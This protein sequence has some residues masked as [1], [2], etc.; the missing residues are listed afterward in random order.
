[1]TQRRLLTVVAILLLSFG[2]TP[3]PRVANADESTG[4]PA[5]DKDAADGASDEIKAAN[6]RIA[7]VLRDRCV[8]CHGES[9]E[10]MGDVDLF[11]FVKQLP[12]VAYLELLQ[13]LTQVIDL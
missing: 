9:D 3:F 4:L 2:E 13:Y 10:I 8:H 1:M 12:E 11:K 6:K 5:T 7:S